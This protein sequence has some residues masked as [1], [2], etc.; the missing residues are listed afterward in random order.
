MLDS[1]GSIGSAEF[2]RLKTTLSTLVPLFCKVNKFAVMSFGAKIERNICFS[3]DQDEDHQTEFLNALL[4]IKYHRGSYT[5]TGDAIQCACD[6]MLKSSCGFHNDNGSVVTDVIL[7]TDGRS[8]KGESPCFA[9]KCFPSHVNVIPVGIGNYAG[10]D[11]ELTCIQDDN[12][13]SGDHYFTLT[14]IDGLEELL[15]NVVTTLSDPNGPKCESI[16]K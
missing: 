13:P 3:C 14:S 9:T 2:T 7:F 1:S 8:N 6:Y 11:E 16:T 4:S 5:R 10:R 12:A 15:Q